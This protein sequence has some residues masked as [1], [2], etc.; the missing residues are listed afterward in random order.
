[1]IEAVKKGLITEKEIDNALAVLLKTRFKLGQ[2]DAP[3]NPYNKISI[4]VI[5]SDANRALAK[6]AALKS[7][8]LLKNNGA[9]PLRNDLSRYL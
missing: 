6:E 5:N 2:F 1:M 7:I 4:D 8:V 3:K 9:L